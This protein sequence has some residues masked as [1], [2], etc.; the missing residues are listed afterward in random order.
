[1]KG[2]VRTGK[3]EIVEVA[4]D[5]HPR[6]QGVQLHAELQKLIPTIGMINEQVI[7]LKHDGIHHEAEALMEG[8]AHGKKLGP[9]SLVELQTILWMVDGFLTLTD[10]ELAHHLREVHG[11]FNGVSTYSELVKAVAELTGGAISLTASYAAA[12]AKLAGDTS[13]AAMATGLARSTGLLFANVIA[14]IEIIHGVAVLLDP[15]ATPQQKVDGAVGASS[16]AAWFIGSRVGGA[17]VGFAAS[18]AI[19]LGYAELKLMAH[20]YWQANVGLTAGFMRLAYETIQRDGESIA[21][22][23]DDLAK[24]GML[25]ESE[26]DPEKAAALQHV[27]TTLIA[28]LGGAVDY[29]I[30]DCKPHGF[31]AGVARYPG[32]Y[33]ILREVFAP[34][35]KHKGAK[36]LEAVT[37]AARVALER[38]TWSMAHAGDLI[39]AS[40]KR[41]N[42]GD[43][44]NEL[45][46]KEHGGEE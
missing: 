5:K 3:H 8:H 24:A 46:K 17:A 44:E 1:V 7:R 10:E 4:D 40:A 11:V 33:T 27:E 30:D 41:Q 15:H 20:L 23:A 28:Q 45:E 13:C 9:G 42:L 14:G 21:R 25:R 43:V 35:M 29:F 2:A 18:T 19:L 16:G 6:Q 26:K 32:A 39:M 38:I 12:I 37:E 31:E 22:C 34:V 36:T